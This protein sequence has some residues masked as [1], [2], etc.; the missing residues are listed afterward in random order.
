MTK[1]YNLVVFIMRGQII[2]KAH[3]EIIRRATELGKEVLVILGSFNRPMSLRNPF[4]FMV[5]REMLMQA[6][7][8]IPEFYDKQ[9][10]ISSVNDHTYDNVAW[11]Q[12][13][14]SVVANYASSNIAIIGHKKDSTSVYLDFFPD[15]E[16]IEIENLGKIDSTKIRNEYFSEHYEPKWLEGVVS[17]SVLEFLDKY[18]ETPEF[19][20]YMNLKK[21]IERYQE[22]Y[23]ALP[24]APIFL[25]ADAVVVKS[26]RVLLVK[27]KAF[28]GKG[29]FALPGGFVD[30]Y[31]DPS[32]YDA[33][34]REL[35]EETRIRVSPE[36][37]NG[38]WK[39]VK[40]FDA[41]HRSDRGRTITEAHFF[42]LGQ[43][44]LPKV[45]AG[46]DASNCVWVPLS[47]LD[48][49]NMFEDHYDIIKYFTS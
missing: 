19:I 13:V 25:T 46:S 32:L 31:T 15:Y 9:I 1:K 18:R 12:E 23:K 45:R 40:T 11:A 33:A 8:V 48:P 42:D 10:Y 30:A 21:F 47:K 26:G 36:E 41:I 35:F 3:E 39:D 38:S 29:L 34:V 20:E 14:E 7:R 49:G 16:L 2:H 27:R 43:G 22:P 24:Y 37:L 5:R 4:N 44:K 17:K 28:P 6:M